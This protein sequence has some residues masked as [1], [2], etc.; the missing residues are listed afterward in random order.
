[1]KVWSWSH[2]NSRSGPRSEIR[3]KLT[4]HGS[5]GSH[6]TGLGCFH[7][8]PCLLRLRRDATIFNDNS[9]FIHDIVCQTAYKALYTVQGP[10][11]NQE[12]CTFACQNLHRHSLPPK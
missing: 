6:A 9:V 12:L 7:P 3:K 8:S 5:R 2:R 11:S 1:M 10:Q 4:L